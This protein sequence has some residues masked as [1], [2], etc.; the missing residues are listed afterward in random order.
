MIQLQPEFFHQQM[1][2]IVQAIQTGMARQE[3]VSYVQNIEKRL[4][5]QEEPPFNYDLER[6]KLHVESPNVSVPQFS[7]P[8]ELDKWI[9]S[10]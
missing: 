8:E 10:L 5:E 4:A 2:L 6:M 1:A 9:M 3:L 7:T